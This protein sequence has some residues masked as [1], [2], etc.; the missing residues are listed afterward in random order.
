MDPC[1]DMRD[2]ESEAHRCFR[3][4]GATCWRAVMSEDKEKQLSLETPGV[5]VS[6]EFEE[7]PLNSSMSWFALRT[8]SNF[9]RQCAFSLSQKGFETFL[10]SYRS[11]RRRW[12]R[13]VDL[14]LP[15][16]PGYLFCR[17][18][19]GHRLPILMS[20]GVV[21]IVGGGSI[22]EPVPEAEIATVRTIVESQLKA[23]PWPF[24]EIGQQVRIT[25]GPLAGVE[26]ILVSAKGR[27]RLVVSITLLQR[28]IAAEIDGTWVRPV[29]RNVDR[30]ASTRVYAGT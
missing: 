12:D 27:S 1:V 10:P 25:A 18:D 17:F 6:R 20:P 7:N 19:F 11:R 23:E 24:L 4:G 26:G 13:T 28:S 2:L 21:H 15:L 5:L 30:I 14:E 3:R 29:A 22:P 9:E 8:R 16:F